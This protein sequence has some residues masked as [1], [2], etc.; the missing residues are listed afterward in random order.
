MGA[1]L[2]EGKLAPQVS[3]RA[4]AFARGRRDD[5]MAM[6]KRKKTPRRKPRPPVRQPDRNRK[7]PR[8][9]PVRRI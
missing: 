8:R 9:A 6:A 3:C 7:A 1:S 4:L 5:G 2:R